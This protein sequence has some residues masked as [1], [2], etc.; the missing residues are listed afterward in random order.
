MQSFNFIDNCLAS[1]QDNN[2]PI[3]QNQTLVGFLRS[4]LRQGQKAFLKGVESKRICAFKARRQYG[5]TTTLAAI[6]LRRMVKMPNHTIIFGTAR[7]NLATELIRKQD[8]L[9]GVT[10]QA[11]ARELQNCRSRREETLT[12]SS[13]PGVGLLTSAPTIVMESDGVGGIPAFGSRKD[14]ENEAHLL[15]SIIA[16]AKP[17]IAAEQKELVV[18][19]ARSGREFKRLRAD[20]F[21]NLFEKR[22]LEFRVYYSPTTYSRTKIVALTPGTVGETGDMIADEIARVQNWEE[23]WEAIE[24][25]SSANAG[26]RIILSSTPSPDDTLLAFEML[27]E[28]TGGEFLVKP[29]GNW[30]ESEFGIPVLRLTAWDAQADGVKMYDPITGETLSVEEHRH[31]Y[32]N[33]EVW[34][35]NYGVRDIISGTGAIGLLEVESAQRLGKETCFYINIKNDDHLRQAKE[36]LQALLGNGTVGCGWDVA[37]T[38]DQTSNPSAFTVIEKT[39]KAIISRLVCIWKTDNDEVQE[40]RVRQLL[41]VI[42]KRP[43]GGPAR[44]LCIDGTNERLF[45]RRMQQRLGQFCTVEPI[46]GSENVPFQKDTVNYKTLLGTNYVD[47]FRRDSLHL[48]SHDYVKED[49]RLVRRDAGHFVCYPTSDGKHGDTFDSGKLALHALTSRGGSGA[50]TEETIK[51]IAIGS[52]RRSCGPRLKL[53]DRGIWGPGGRPRLL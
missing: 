24:P 25:I 50:I 42:S 12:D 8:E 21:A 17:V 14:V 11:I 9:V 3:Q 51:M 47:A 20:D 35:R 19:D 45:A 40:A 15:S 31:R 39:E 52:N 44:R 23:V 41:E 38:T 22:R 53:G 7:L 13:G 34:E 6:A 27:R 5:K 36:R 28:P 43:S 2:V 33:E 26:Y 1:R 30:F 16:E 32:R 48:P 4:R 49:H 37:T 18:A 10:R 29:E 46:V